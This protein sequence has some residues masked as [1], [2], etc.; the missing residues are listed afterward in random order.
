MR[1]IRGITCERAGCWHRSAVG[2]KVMSLLFSLYNN[3]DQFSNKCAR[4]RETT[5]KIT[6]GEKNSPTEQSHLLVR[7]LETAE[8]LPQVEHGAD[9]VVTTS[10]QTSDRHCL[11][12]LTC[13]VYRIRCCFCLDSRE[14]DRGRRC[15]HQLQV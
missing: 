11:Q 12:P 9:Q 8:P 2:E 5:K 15:H 13:P 3:V 4:V 6:R 1:G 10:K 7:Q 14:T